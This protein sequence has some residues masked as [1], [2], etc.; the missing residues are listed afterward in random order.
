LRE[1]RNE[2]KSG[3]ARNI[4]ERSNLLRTPTNPGRNKSMPRQ[5]GKSKELSNP[6]KCR[7]SK[8]IPRNGLLLSENLFQTTPKLAKPLTN[9]LKEGQN[10]IWT[11]EHEHCI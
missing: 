4:S 5:G 3:K 2:T 1:S 6:R 8:I 9:A 11:S 7:P 10:F